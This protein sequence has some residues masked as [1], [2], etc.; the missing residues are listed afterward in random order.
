MKKINSAGDSN[1][2]SRE[3]IVQYKNRPMHLKWGNTIDKPAL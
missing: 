1:N 3:A 2:I